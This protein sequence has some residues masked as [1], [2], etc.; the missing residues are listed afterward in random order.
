VL[1]E[2]E[3]LTLERL[4]NRR[5]TAQAMALRARIVLACAED[6]RPTSQEVAARLKLNQATVGTWRRRFV[7]DRLDGLYDEPRPG[8]PRTVTDDMVEKIVVKTLE[9]TPTDA[10]H[11]AGRSMA[12]ATGMSATT[13]G[14]I[15]VGLRVKA[16][17]DRELQALHRPPFH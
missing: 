5:K 2:Q 4:T 17:P 6:R 7:A 8:A 14:R 16:P 10:T 12:R 9:E 3:R 1:S 15:L 11:W 13:I